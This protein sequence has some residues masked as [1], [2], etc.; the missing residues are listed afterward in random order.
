M[1]F[2][3]FAKPSL[4]EPGIKYYLTETLKQCNHFK[5]QHYNL[6]VNIGISVLFVLILG[7]FLLYNYK[8]K[9]TPAEKNEREK[10]KQQYILRS[11]KN[12]QTAKLHAQ[13]ELITGLPHWDNQY[14]NTHNK[15][16]I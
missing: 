1:Y 13:Q 15:I 5:S 7:G 11:I 4:I 3:D 8:G 14:D 6:L 10:E 16:N 12:Y 9:L 2:E